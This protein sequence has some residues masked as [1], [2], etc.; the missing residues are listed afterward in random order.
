MSS[1]Y[2]MSAIQSEEEA[3]VIETAVRAAVQSVVEVINNISRI[4]LL[5][6]QRKVA[7]KDHRLYEKDRE[8]ALLK[9][10]VVKAEKE[11]AFLRQ[12]VGLRQDEDVHAQNTTIQV[13]E[14]ELS[15]DTSCAKRRT[16]T[17]KAAIAVQSSLK[18]PKKPMSS[19]E[20]QRLY[21][22]R[23]DA[24]PGRRAEYLEAEKRRWI[25]DKALGKKKLIHECSVTEKRL[26]RRRWRLAQE[27]RKTTKVSSLSQ[28][29]LNSEQSHPHAGHSS[30]IHFGCLSLET[31]ATVR[32]DLV[33]G[34]S[35]EVCSTSE[36]SESHVDFV[37]GISF[38]VVKEEPPHTDT[39]YIKFEVKEEN[40]STN[41][42]H[43]SPSCA[44]ERETLENFSFTQH[45]PEDQSGTRERYDGRERAR[46]YRERIRADPEKQQA[47]LERDRRRYQQR[48][49][50]IHE[51]P[52][53]IQR[54]RR[55][56]W[57]EAARRSRARKKSHIF[58]WTE[59]L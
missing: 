33:T 48:K 14:N 28:A 26:K 15:V 59:P 56:M 6:Y 49:K 9:A 5:D 42:D 32:G 21:R 45:P 24:D 13:Q 12:L 47:Y 44:L 35:A 8:N 36:Y 1:G 16:G 17:N 22:A 25:R 52:D 29:S 39:V 11:L 53:E 7:E 55:E 23:R 27:K 18:Q 34:S 54:R 4:R 46:R 58:Q 41:Q 57:R 3:R 19:A 38:P 37:T 43:S 2:Q 31:T 50:L 40:T 51:L 10:E 30:D 20:K